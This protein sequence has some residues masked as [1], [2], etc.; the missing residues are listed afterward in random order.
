MKNLMLINAVALAVGAISSLA[1]T[2]SANI[3][4]YVNKSLP[5]SNAYSQISAP[6]LAGTNTVEAAMPMI[7]KGDKV[8]FWTGVSFN[9]LTYAGTNFDSYGHAWLD[10]Q[11]NGQDSP[12]INQSRGFFYQNNGTAVTNTFV[13]TIPMTNSIT[14]PANHA[15]NLL[16]SAIPICDALDSASLSLPFHT[17]D[18]VLIWTGS[19]YNAFTYQGANFDGLGHAF[20]DG[21]GQAQPTPVIQVGQAFLYQNNQDSPEIWNQSLKIQ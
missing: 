6:F 2:Y 13:G 7:K 4:G 17:G 10:S 19:H 21:T 3:V 14:I 16:G 12:P 5:G 18:M 11:G 20:T 1:Q 8:S 15:Y 9:T